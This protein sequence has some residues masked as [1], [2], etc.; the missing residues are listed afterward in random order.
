MGAGVLAVS[1]LF[2][3]QQVV[4]GHGPNP[5]DYLFVGEAPGAVEDQKGLPFQGPSGKLLDKTLAYWTELRR[6]DVWATNIVK[7]RPP[8]NRDP[9]ASEIKA[10]LPYFTDELER[11]NPKVVV[12]LGGI[13]LKVFEKKG[14]VTECHGT[15][16]PATLGNWSGLLVSWFHPAFALRSPAAFQAFALDAGRL[17]SQVGVASALVTPTTYRMATEDDVIEAYRKDKP[18]VVGFDT[19]TTSPTQGRK[20]F[21][22]D[23]AEMVGWSISWKEGNGYYVPATDFGVSMRWLLRSHV[24]KICHNAKFE[25]KILRKLGV[26]MRNFEDTKVAAYLIGEPLTGLKVLARQWLGVQPETFDDV[27]GGKDMSEIP[28]E[29]IVSY[30]AADADNTRRLWGQLAPMVEKHNVR[31]VYEEIEMPI[32][33]IL[34]R[35]EARGVLVDEPQTRKALVEIDD[36]L[37]QSA[38]NC[39]NLL[40]PLPDGFNLNSGDQLEARLREM[41]APLKKRTDSGARYAVDTDAIEKLRDWYPQLVDYLTTYRKYG[42]M[43]TYLKG[44]IELRGPDLRLHSAL[45]QSG[46]FEEIGGTGSAPSTGR[47]SSSGPNLTNIPHHRA[48]IEGVDWGAKIRSCLVA[49]EGYVLVSADLAQEEPRIISVVAND[50][51]LISAFAQGSDIYRAA[52]EALYPY[53]ADGTPDEVWKLA[54]EDWE[55]YIGKQDF[56]AWYYGAGADRLRK[57]DPTLAMT[58]I[59]AGLAGLSKAHPARDGYIAETREQLETDG[60]TTSLFGRK[61]WYPG[62]WSRKKVEREEALRQAANMRIQGTA[63]DLLKIALARIDRELKGWK[64]GLL[65]T[66]HDELVLEVWKPE[67]AQVVDIL[68]EAFRGL[69]PGVELILEVFVGERWGERTRYMA[70]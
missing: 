5:C 10:S 24:R 30:A 34:G 22:T 21:M 9:K 70:V 20:V 11:V 17:A 62:A 68:H 64:S 37:E 36:A 2:P 54:W 61:R 18:L 59:K 46:H 25:Y 13:A 23:Q 69:L 26:E 35:M 55:R 58:T 32:V 43:G 27:T 47:L 49:P 65:F 38:V 39:W 41:G 56:L 1:N 63:A 3:G 29:D 42:K 28:A 48:K 14:K 4:L 19:E 52:T 12:T 8:K 45:N 31:K 6:A 16:R 53:T 44:F 67:L 40:E 51:T 7:Q 33:P 57:L 15:V 60:F 50:E 66:V